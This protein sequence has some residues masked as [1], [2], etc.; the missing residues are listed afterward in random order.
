MKILADF[1]K[2]V[3]EIGP[4][5]RAWFT[6]FGLSLDL[7][8]RYI[9][10]A[11]VGVDPP[12]TPQEFETLQAKAFGEDT[13]PRLDLK[14]FYDIRTRPNDR[15]KRTSIPLYG[16]DFRT[17]DLQVQEGRFKNGFFHPKVIYLEGEKGEVIGAG[18]ANLSVDGWAKNRE[19]FHFEKLVGQENRAEITHFFRRIHHWCGLKEDFK[20]PPVRRDEQSNQRWRFLSS[21]GKESFLDHLCGGRDPGPLVVWS[22]FLSKDLAGLAK[23]LVK[24]HGV[25]WLA[26]VPDRHPQGKI[27]LSQE[28]ASLFLRDGNELRTDDSIDW[29]LRFSHAKIWMT[30]RN[31]AIGSWNLTGPATGYSKSKDKQ[32]VEAGFV[33]FKKGHDLPAHLKVL[34]PR[35]A[36]QDADVLA[37]EQDQWMASMEPPKVPVSVKFD[38]SQRVWSWQLPPQGPWMD[39]QPALVLPVGDTGPLVVDLRE[40]PISEHL[41]TDPG[42]L[43]RQ[44]TVEVRHFEKGHWRSVP[45]WIVELHPEDRPINRFDTWDD[46]L[47]GLIA[48]RPESETRGVSSLL[49]TDESEALEFSIDG[50]HRGNESSNM[51]SYFRMFAAMKGARIQLVKADSEKALRRRIS[52]YPGCLTEILDAGARQLDLR[53][54]WSPVYRWF[55]IQE[56]RL[57]LKSAQKRWKELTP[58]QEIPELF[59]ELRKRLPPL[60]SLAGKD[61]SALRYL[62]NAK[63]EAGYG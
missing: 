35:E 48:G 61:S 19:C 5:R 9:L 26:V 15:V 1:K 47:A 25:D 12:T 40:S 43:L 31:L 28:S 24:Q 50:K 34:E 54:D 10:P 16:V 56:L 49:G 22:P 23:I 63:K 4:V 51:V 18:S 38:L 57:L 60:P 8:E 17:A 20:M 2:I 29:N 44:R 14:V 52:V 39:C 36:T 55:L 53:K 59:K 11:L 33:L 6:T 62:E 7:L 45:L 21:I 46:L 42:F 32:N 30:R 58:G 13:E 27:R 37:K 3:Q 41:V